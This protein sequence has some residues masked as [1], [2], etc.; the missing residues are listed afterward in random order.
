MS[1][2]INLFYFSL[3]KHSIFFRTFKVGQGCSVDLDLASYGYCQYVSQFHASIFFDQYSRIFE[4][5]NYRW[6]ILLQFQ[7]M[8][9]S[10]KIFQYQ[11]IAIPKY[12]NT[13]ILQSQNIAI[14][15]C[16]NTKILQY[17]NIAVPKYI[18]QYQNTYCNTK[19]LQYQNVVTFLDDFSTSIHA[20]LR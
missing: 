5:I 4:L 13:K 8:V 11:N 10:T 1:Q 19:I 16:C 17:Q 15:K 14:P 18:L 20:F 2:C 7:N 6:V 3:N 12:C 9:C